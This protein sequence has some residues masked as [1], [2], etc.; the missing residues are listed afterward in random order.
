MASRPATTIRVRDARPRDFKALLAI[1]TASHPSA[2]SRSQ[3]RRMIADPSSETWVLELEDRVAGFLVL[4]D[5][6]EHWHLANL[7]IAP[8]LRRRGLGRLALRVLDE[9][10]A[11]R[12]YTKVILHVRESNLPAQLLYRSAG[13]RAVEIV[14]RY[15]GDEPAYRMEK[16][17]RPG[18]TVS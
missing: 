1:E 3:M 5:E 9:Q 10:V 11:A 18:S 16:D 14:K 6:E 17:V 12:P 13:Y 7:A 8:D 4:L 2:W 15:Y